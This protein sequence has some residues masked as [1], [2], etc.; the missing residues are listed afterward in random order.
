MGFEM[1]ISDSDWDNQIRKS[2]LA[3]TSNSTN[4]YN[5]PSKYGQIQLCAQPFR[6]KDKKCYCPQIHHAPIIDGIPDK[7]WDNI[8]Y[9]PVNSIAEGKIYSNSDH[10][11]RFKTAWDKDGIY[12]LVNVNDNV[13]TKPNFVKKDYCWIEDAKTGRIVWSVNVKETPNYPTFLSCD[14]VKLP[15]GNYHLRYI[16]D[17]A[18]SFAHWYFK[19]PSLDFYGATA[20]L[21]N[22]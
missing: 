20:Y 8:S 14:T 9:I 3:W 16:S 15:S 18:H 2:S 19:I 4:D 12:F 6:A 11:A 1:Y 21:L 17:N 13:K 22:K 10:S 7:V 5:K